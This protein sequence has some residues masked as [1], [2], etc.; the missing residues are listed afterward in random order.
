MTI[1][2]IIDNALIEDLGDGDHTSRSTIPA[3]ATGKAGLFIKQKG[4]LAGI[5]IAE[6][7]FHKVDPD[8]KFV[9]MME[10]GSEIKPCPQEM[11]QLKP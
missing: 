10:D 7:V 11:S 8:T 9:A 5:N 1:D 6:K 2:Q 4:L 3:T